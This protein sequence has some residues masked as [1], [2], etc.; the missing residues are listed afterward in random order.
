MPVQAPTRRQ[1]GGTEG[2]RR[3]RSRRE[4]QLTILWKKAHTGFQFIL[5]ILINIPDMSSELTWTHLGS[6]ITS[7]LNSLGNTIDSQNHLSYLP[8]EAASA[9][10]RLVCTCPRQY[11]LC[12]LRLALTCPSCTFSISREIQMPSSLYFQFRLVFL[13]CTPIRTASAIT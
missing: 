11:F 9:P 13:L 4:C 8:M 12:P 3:K 1:R 5:P 10:A 6:D 7:V 2:G